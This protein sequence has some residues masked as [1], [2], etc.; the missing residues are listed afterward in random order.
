VQRRND[1]MVVNHVRAKAQYEW[2]EFVI[3]GQWCP[4]LPKP[5]LSSKLHSNYKGVG[6]KCLGHGKRALKCCITDGEGWI[7]TKVDVINPFYICT[8]I[9]KGMGCKK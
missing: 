1:Q 7:F 9:K 8:R 5:T 3:V 6:F 4:P 2:D